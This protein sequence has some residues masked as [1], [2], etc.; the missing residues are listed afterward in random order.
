M[1]EYTF[2]DNFVFCFKLI[3]LIVFLFCLHF[4]ILSHFEIIR[5]IVKSLI[6]NSTYFFCWNTTE[7]RKLEKCFLGGRVWMLKWV[8][9]SPKWPEYVIVISASCGKCKTFKAEFGEHWILISLWLLFLLYSSC[10]FFEVL[11]KAVTLVQK[12]FYFFRGRFCNSTRYL[13]AKLD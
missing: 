6:T 3:C 11:W 4:C 8:Y 2:V 1:N 13:N 9:Q 10:D 7:K 12:M 5:C